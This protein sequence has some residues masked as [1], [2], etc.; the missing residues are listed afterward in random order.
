M[1]Q[2]VHVA[3]HRWV[4]P[5]HFDVARPV[6]NE[7]DVEGAMAEDLIGDITVF[8]LD[9]P[10]LRSPGRP[11]RGRMSPGM[12]DRCASTGSDLGFPVVHRLPSRRQAIAPGEAK[13]C[14]CHE[15]AVAPDT[16]T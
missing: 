15:A 8:A 6:A 7:H 5:H 3:R 4:F 12:A 13:T 11:D 10:D 2:M 14:A 1:T 9:V 16:T